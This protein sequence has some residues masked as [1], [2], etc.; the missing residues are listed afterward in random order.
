MR[1]AVATMGND[2]LA[3]I[4]SHTGRA[5]YFL[6]F[7]E[8]GYLLDALQNPYVE[9]RHGAGRDAAALLAEQRVDFLISGK[10]GPTLLEHLTRHG[11]RYTEM[12]GRAQDA[13]RNIL[14]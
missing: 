11:I 3:N 4:S 8:K 7:D 13:V 12:T 10:F 5:R 9:A 1:I 6:I 2:P 14:P